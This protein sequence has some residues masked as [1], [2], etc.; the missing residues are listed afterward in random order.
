MEILNKESIILNEKLNTKHEVIE[1]LVNKLNLCGALHEANEFFK[2]VI[3][4]E[5]LENTYIDFDFAIPHGKSDAVKN[6][7]VAFLRLD[8][9]IVWGEEKEF[10]K[11]IFLIAVPNQNKG[12]IHI[13]MLVKLSKKILKESFREQ[14]AL[15]KNSEEIYKLIND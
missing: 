12:D 1:N 15:A 3:K 5:E 6:P 2:E 14:L 11:N 8:E 9:P 10:A 13:E 7:Q 4:R